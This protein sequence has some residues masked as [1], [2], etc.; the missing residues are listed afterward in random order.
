VFDPVAASHRGHVVVPSDTESTEV[1][2]VDVLRQQLVYNGEVLDIA[3]ESLRS[4]KEGTQTLAYLHSSVAMA[5]A[6]MKMGN[7]K[8][9]GDV[10]G[11]KEGETETED[12][13]RVSNLC[14]LVERD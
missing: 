14:I 8:A 13:R 4:Y 3:P 5:Y 10:C 9:G 6:L 2:A 12:E 11:E 1:E 7:E